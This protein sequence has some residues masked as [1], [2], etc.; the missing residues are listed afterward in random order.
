VKFFPESALSSCQA[1]SPI[2]Q[3]GQT[4]T[5]C[6][7]VGTAYR[8]KFYCHYLYL[9]R[10]CRTAKSLQEGKGPPAFF[11]QRVEPTNHPWGRRREVPEEG[12]AAPVNGAGGPTPALQGLPRR[13]PRS[14]T[15]PRRGVL[16]QRALSKGAG[17][18]TPGLQGSLGSRPPAGSLPSK[19][20]TCA[21]RAVPKRAGAHHAGPQGPTASKSQFFLGGNASSFQRGRRSIPQSWYTSRSP[22]PRGPLVSF[23]RADGRK[24]YPFQRRLRC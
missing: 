9:I 2:R 11:F 6:S 24:A 1:G 8:K 15:S 4:I 3:L 13:L 14:G 16:T 23:S 10:S 12:R 22:C 5:C 17:G 19:G 18:H 7:K 20:K 21:R